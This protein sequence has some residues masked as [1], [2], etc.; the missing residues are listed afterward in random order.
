M[1][2]LNSQVYYS[3][4][5]NCFSEFLFS[6]HYMFT[7]VTILYCRT[8]AIVADV[9]SRILPLENHTFIRIQYK[10]ATEITMEITTEITTEICISYQHVL[11][12]IVMKKGSES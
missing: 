5:S 4:Y 6:M 10:F 9:Q 1:Q 2:L 11:P 8:V 12:L 7:T 3:I